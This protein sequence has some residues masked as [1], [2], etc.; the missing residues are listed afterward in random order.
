MNSQEIELKA[1]SPQ[2]QLLAAVYRVS[3]EST[4]ELIDRIEKL[5]SSETL[6]RERRGKRYDLRPLVEALV[7]DQGGIWMRLAA[8]PNATGRPDE[9]LLALGLDPLALPIH[10]TQLIFLQ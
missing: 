4:P 10:R 1:K 2:S 6:P 5:L 8:R 7:L 9:V 3:L